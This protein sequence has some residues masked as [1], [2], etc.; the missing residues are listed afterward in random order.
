[1]RDAFEPNVML[2]R[3]VRFA[4]SVQLSPACAVDMSSLQHAG[5]LFRA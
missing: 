4:M 5:E 2:Y 1:M 3:L